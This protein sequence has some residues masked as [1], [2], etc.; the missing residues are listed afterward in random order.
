[1]LSM[2]GKRPVNLGA[3]GNRLAPIPD[4]PNAVASQSEKESQRIKA[5]ELGD[6]SG[7]ETIQQIRSIVESMPRS[8]V[9][10]AT[11]IY[12]YAEFHSLIF[13]FTD[14]V[15]FLVDEDSKQLNVRSASRVGYSD[16]GVNRKRVEAIFEQLSKTGQ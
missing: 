4:S 16:M 2:S 13:R 8:K 14:D 3:S 10:E 5:F 11:D 1:M 6:L 9:I 7:S 12:L 15:E